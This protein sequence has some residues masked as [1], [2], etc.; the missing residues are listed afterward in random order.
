MLYLL[1]YQHI[2]GDEIVVRLN[3]AAINCTG[4]HVSGF[5]FGFRFAF[6][7]PGFSVE[8]GA[9]AAAFSF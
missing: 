1:R 2:F 9:F 5:G 6:V 7:L 4:K 3:I 8:I